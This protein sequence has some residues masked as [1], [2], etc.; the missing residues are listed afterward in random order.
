VYVGSS[1]VSSTPVPLAALPVA[2]VRASRSGRSAAVVRVGSA[3]CSDPHFVQVTQEVSRIGV[4]AVRARPLQLVLAVASGHEPDAEGAG[5]PRREEIPDA[6]AHHDGL[7]NGAAEHIG[8][9][10]EQIGIRL[11]VRDQVPRDDGSIGRHPETANRATDSNRL[12][13]EGVVDRQP[14]D[15]LP[16]L[17]LLAQQPRASRG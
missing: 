14:L 13:H 4:D 16:V 12:R 6:V 8:G 1:V 9:G 11:R 5:P 10:Y 3:H 15:A 7:L 17:Q 2:K